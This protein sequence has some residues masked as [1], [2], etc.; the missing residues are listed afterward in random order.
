MLASIAERAVDELGLVLLTLDGRLGID[1]LPPVPEA[2]DEADH[3]RLVAL[4]LVYRL[5]T[6]L[7]DFADTAQ[8]SERSVNEMFQRW[9]LAN[10]PP[11][12]EVPHVE[13]EP[14]IFG[15][16]AFAARKNAA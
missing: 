1:K 7:K 12:E 10:E 16:A 2:S 8:E 5:A 4:S 11:M 14:R 3:R 15:F 6:I 9:E 13:D